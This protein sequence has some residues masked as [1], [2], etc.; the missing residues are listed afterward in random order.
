MK[1][2][3]V[4]KQVQ[5]GFTLIEL[6]IV[7]AIIG[8]LA[9]VAIPAYQ[10]YT[11]KSKFGAACGSSG[12]PQRSRRAL[13][14]CTVVSLSG[15]AVIVCTPGSSA[16]AFFASTCLLAQPATQRANAPPH[17]IDRKTSLEGCIG[18]LLPDDERCKPRAS[19]AG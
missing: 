19:H 4:R 7:V 3:K 1:M 9:A 13:E 12:M 8:I 11:A 2:L 10:D 14:I 5:K 6:M 16:V 17:Q 18:S 15:E